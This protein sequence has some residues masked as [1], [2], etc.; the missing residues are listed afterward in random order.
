MIH[1]DRIRHLI[2]LACNDATAPNEA[3]NAALQACR[4]IKRHN[5]AVGDPVSNLA[6]RVCHTPKRKPQ[7]NA[8][9]ERLISLKHAANCRICL[10]PMYPG[11]FAYWNKYTGA[12]HPDCEWPENWS[13]Q[14]RRM[15]EDE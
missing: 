4:L 13:E 2:E 11:E 9:G 5:V 14:D 1:L 6:A 7:P 12:R 3:R 8:S 15:H 10:I